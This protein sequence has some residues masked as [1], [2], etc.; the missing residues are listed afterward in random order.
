MVVLVVMLVLAVLGAR[1]LDR[2][3][4]S[5][6]VINEARVGMVVWPPIESRGPGSAVWAQAIDTRVDGLRE[7]QTT[8]LAASP[9]RSQI[10]EVV[11]REIDDEPGRWGVA[12][13]DL[14]TGETYIHNGDEYFPS[15]S[16][17]K[18]VV[19]YVVFR[20]G[21]SMDEVLTPRK[22]HFREATADD[23]LELGE[24]IRVDDA[25]DAMITVSSNAAAYLLADRVGWERI[26]RACDELGMSHTGLPYGERRDR[27][28]DWRAEMAS[29]SPRDMLRYFSLMATGRLIDPSASS[30]MLHVLANQRINDRFPALLPSGVGV[31]H[32]TGNLHNIV[33]DAGIVYGPEGRF[34]LVVLA[35][36]T[37][38]GHASDAQ[39]RLARALYDL[40]LA[41]SSD[42]VETPDSRQ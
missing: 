35:R 7:R 38:S 11:H 20:D 27:F 6:V 39:A 13:R 21:V 36:D 37:A 24:P 3:A 15:A 28:D 25:L 42:S 31:A 5:D 17:Y 40:V 23:P 8:A 10:A 12:V 1:V 29:T 14:Q 4:Q 41:G 26:N 32:K 9:S 22:E 33:N 30:R 18:L 16:L 34:I 19:M 2:R